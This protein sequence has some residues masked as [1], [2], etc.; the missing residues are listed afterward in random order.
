MNDTEPDPVPIEPARQWES[1]PVR[2]ATTA[3]GIGIV[4]T[5]VAAP[6]AT[7]YA[8]AAGVA[9]VVLVAGGQTFI[10]EQRGGQTDPAADQATSSAPDRGICACGFDPYVEKNHRPWCKVFGRP[11]GSLAD[12]LGK[13]VQVTSPANA[14]WRGQLVA[15]ADHPALVLDAGRGVSFVLP[16]DYRVD[17]IEDDPDGSGQD[18]DSIRTATDTAGQQATDQGGHDPDALRT[19]LAAAL[20]EDPHADWHYLTGRAAEIREGRD[21]ADAEC[22]RLRRMVDEYSAGA[23]GLSDKLRAARDA[24]AEAIMCRDIDCLTRSHLPK[25]AGILGGVGLLSD[26]EPTDGSSR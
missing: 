3:A 8:A 1:T 15:L 13:R 4:M 19:R 2:W 6:H 23:R 5:L 18:P 9:L 7:G 16:Q 10:R 21:R 12:L 14:A 22:N 25:I 20:H 17:V 11:G 24:V 26:A